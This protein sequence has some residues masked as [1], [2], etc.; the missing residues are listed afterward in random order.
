MARKHAQPRS[1]V[2]RF[3]GGLRESRC[4]RQRARVR[5]PSPSRDEAY[6]DAQPRG[7]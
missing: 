7:L 2:L 4:R 5:S 6:R 1:D 3:T